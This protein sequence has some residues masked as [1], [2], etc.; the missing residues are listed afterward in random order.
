MDRGRKGEEKTRDEN[1][2]KE[3]NEWETDEK[4]ENKRQT[5]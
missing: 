5:D 2:E 4:R 3:L 1:E